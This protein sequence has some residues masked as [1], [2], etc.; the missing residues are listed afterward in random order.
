MKFYHGTSNEGL[1]FVLNEGKLIYPRA[2]KSSPN[3]SPVVY[4]A[5]EITAAECYGPVVLEVEY[6][7]FEY[8]ETNNYC[9][10]C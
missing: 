10:G 3:A 7:P 1:N 8:P 6:D 9:K 2:T 4:L 5:T